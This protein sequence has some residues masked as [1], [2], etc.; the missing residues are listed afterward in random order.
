MRL[1]GKLEKLDI[2]L[3]GNRGIKLQGCLATISWLNGR[4]LKQV[5]L[6]GLESVSDADIYALMSTSGPRLQ[7]L[8]VAS[9]VSNS[10]EN[11]NSNIFDK[12]RNLSEL[13]VS[14]SCGL[15]D[16]HRIS[17]VFE[18]LANLRSLKLDHLQ[19]NNS[20]IYELL[21]RLKMLM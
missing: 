3:L 11:F 8:Q 1:F 7:S 2:G 17:S 12:A 19:I 16:C 14:F 10:S 15:V 5:D 20:H 18:R 21:W 13:D 6:C 9:S 4:R